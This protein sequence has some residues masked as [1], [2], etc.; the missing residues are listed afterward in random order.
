MQ[1][2]SAT[3]LKELLDSGKTPVILDVREDWEY[4]ICHIE[5]S[6]HISM[7][8]LPARLDELNRDDEIIV[9]CHHGARSMQVA[10]YMEAQGFQRIS[11]LTGGIHEWTESVDPSMPQY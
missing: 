2:L 4:D 9:I 8:S 3:E 1:Q 5:P 11:N 7:S 6:V 10:G